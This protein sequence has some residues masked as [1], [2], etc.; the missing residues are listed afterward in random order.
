[1]VVVSVALRWVVVEL[2]LAAAVLGVL[3]HLTQRPTRFV[4]MFAAY[5]TVSGALN[6]LALPLLMLESGQSD[7]VNLVDYLLLGFFFWNVLALGNILRHG[8]EIS[9]AMG[10]GCA[11]AY[12]LCLL[13]LL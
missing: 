4:Q 6:L 12:A 5:C 1:M 11:L 7:Q 13:L 10:S 9:L 2:L 3:L 8:L